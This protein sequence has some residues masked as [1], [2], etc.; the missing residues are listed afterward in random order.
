MYFH[1]DGVSFLLMYKTR[2]SSPLK[3][4]DRTAPSPV[5][6][7]SMCTVKGRE[8]SGF[9]RSQECSIGENLVLTVAAGGAEGSF[10]LCFWHQGD[11]L[12]AFIRS[13]VEMNR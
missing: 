7:A 13:R 4:W 12:V 11:L 1:S 5:S 2:C 3:V 6:D 8:K 9:L 10:G